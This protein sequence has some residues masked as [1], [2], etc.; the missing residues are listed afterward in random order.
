VSE[1][2]SFAA[3]LLAQCQL[4][5]AALRRVGSP[6]V[7][8]SPHLCHRKILLDAVAAAPGAARPPD[9]AT[10]TI[11]APDGSSSCQRPK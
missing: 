2:A 1:L 9:L 5:P 4:G 11:G 7:G 3:L 8:D 10:G 6:A